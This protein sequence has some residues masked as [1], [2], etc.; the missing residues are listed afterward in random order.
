MSGESPTQNILNQG[1]GGA[2]VCS[3]GTGSTSP[4]GSMMPNSV[5]GSPGMEAALAAAASAQL[6]PN[7]NAQVPSNQGQVPSNQGQVPQNIGLNYQQGLGQ[8]QM[9][10]QGQGQP[11]MMGQQKAGMLRQQSQQ[12]MML[13]SSSALASSPSSNLQSQQNM[14][15]M[16]SMGSNPIQS[17]T[18]GHSGMHR[19]SSGPRLNPSQQFPSRS[20]IYGQLPF[21]HPLQQ[22]QLTGLT[23]TGM[24]GQPQGPTHLSMLNQASPFSSIQSHLMQQARQKQALQSSHFQQSVSSGQSLQGMQNIGMMGSLGLTS[25]S[26][27]NG[28]LAFT[29]QRAA[30]RSPSTP[31]QQSLSSPQK[32]QTQNLPRVPSIGSMNSQLTGLS[33]GGQSAI[34]PGSLAHPQQ[35]SKLQ[36]SSLTSSASP[37]YQLQQQQQQRQQQAQLQQQAPPSLSQQQPITSHS[38]QL[39]QQQNSPQ[40]QQQQLQQSLQ[41]QSV[42]RMAPLT[43]QKP[44]TPTG[45][46]SGTSTLSA[47][48]PLGTNSQGAEGS[49][50]ILQK[51]TIHDLVAQVDPNETIDPELADFLLEFADDFIQS[52][53]QWA[54]A[55]AKHR[56]SPIVDEKD[57]LL[58]LE[59]NW[60]LSIPGYSSKECNKK[61]RVS[62]SEAHQNR[63]ALIQKSMTVSQMEPEA[64][65]NKS[66]T[67][68]VNGSSNAIIGSPNS[69][70]QG[71]KAM[72]NST[73]VAPFSM[74]SPG[75]QKI[76]RF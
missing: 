17:P 37:P 55:Y 41:P 31:Q 36:Q 14:G 27:M 25:Q 40:I 3:T 2:Q 74:G 67:G 61:Q 51:R 39:S 45:S 8:M 34:V 19:S 70:V 4:L 10:G 64:G 38:Q 76:P 5:V 49:L 20:T 44:S 53:T 28:S 9:Q 60:K 58:H 29:Q 62:G 11:Q 56:N 23:R 59:H 1:G 6:N 35:W 72:Q 18:S 13:S 30:L 71:V 24:T 22:Q 15:A 42:N 46:Q 12:M 33:Q 52:A 69:G 21:N 54:C 7:P 75:V 66:A 73:S 32:I 16:G 50:P 43:I 68:S 47:P 57:M 26:R 63:L 65:Q 48:L